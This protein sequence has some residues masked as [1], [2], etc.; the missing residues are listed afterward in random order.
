[1]VRRHYILAKGLYRFEQKDCP[2]HREGV[3]FCRPFFRVGLW[4]RYALPFPVQWFL[5]ITVIINPVPVR[6]DNTL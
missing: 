3:S 1:M 6:L 4:E 5:T 2:D